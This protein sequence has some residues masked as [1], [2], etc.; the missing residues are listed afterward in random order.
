VLNVA[1]NRES[2]GPGIGARAEAK[3]DHT[4]AMLRSLETRVRAAHGRGGGALI[5]QAIQT[6]T[7][8]VTP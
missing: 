7:P 8:N 3:A 5:P 6:F 4:G 2:T 1:G